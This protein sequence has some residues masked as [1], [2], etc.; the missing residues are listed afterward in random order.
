M[1][2][3]GKNEDNIVQTFDYKRLAYS[4]HVHALLGNF[5]KVFSNVNPQAVEGPANFII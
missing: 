4:V 2:G 3:G 5:N 1:N